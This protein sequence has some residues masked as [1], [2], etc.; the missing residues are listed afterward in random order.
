MSA[1]RSKVFVDTNV[2]VYAQDVDEGA[3]YEAAKRRVQQLWAD[4]TGVLSTQVLQE[5]YVTLTRKITHPM[6]RSSAREV[7]R[8]YRSWVF[9]AIEAE[10]ILRAS[11]LEESQDIH[12]W[13]SL[14]V[15]SAAASGARTLL[16]EDLNHGQVIEGVRIENPF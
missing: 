12:F 9:G 3:K 13:D 6:D 14:I 16:T 7:V 11:E 10:H 4:G 8:R 5:L 2:L 1:S 15:V